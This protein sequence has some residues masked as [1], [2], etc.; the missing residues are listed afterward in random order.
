MAHC[1]GRLTHLGLVRF[2][3]GDFYYY[4]SLIV[5]VAGLVLGFVMLLKPVLTFLTLGYLVALCLVAFGID[6]ILLA[7]SNMG[8]RW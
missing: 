1:I 7:F 5:H 6:C 4:F 2:V 3:A 8:S